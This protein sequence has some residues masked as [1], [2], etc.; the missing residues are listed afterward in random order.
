MKVSKQLKKGRVAK[1][2]KFKM[3]KKSKTVEFLVDTLTRK[4]NFMDNKEEYEE[5]KEYI[6]IGDDQ[7]VLLELHYF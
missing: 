2:Q 4:F 1:E 7:L 6:I 5:H 3:S